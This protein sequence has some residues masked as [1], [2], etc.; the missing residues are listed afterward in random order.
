MGEISLFSDITPV[1]VMPSNWIRFVHLVERVEYLGLSPLAL[2]LSFSLSLSF[3]FFR[4]SY[5][6]VG[7]KL[8]VLRTS[9]F[10]PIT[11]LYISFDLA[12]QNRKI[13][14]CFSCVSNFLFAF[15]SLSIY[16]ITEHF[17]KNMNRQCISRTKLFLYMNVVYCCD[18]HCSVNL[19][20]IYYNFFYFPR[21]IQFNFLFVI[22]I[23]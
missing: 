20:Y 9:S 12:K 21:A 19:H 15:D 4:F 14:I 23:I 1:I 18:K 17:Y 10:S 11:I 3:F 6:N 13:Y 2:T 8:A 22:V 5:A 16:F 7:T